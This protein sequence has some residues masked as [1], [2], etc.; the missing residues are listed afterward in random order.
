MRK[1][2]THNLHMQIANDTMSYIYNYIDTDIN[3]DDLA[4]KFDLSK[5]HLHKIFKEQMDANIYETIKSIRLQKASNLLISNKYSTVTQIANM[6]GYSSQ[7]SFIRAFKNRFNQTPKVWR[8]GAY[9]K[10][11]DEIL[12]SS[13]IELF[14]MDIFSSIKVKVIKTKKQNAYYIRH[15]GYNGEEVTKI[16]QKMQAWLYTNNIKEHT[17]IGIYHDNPIITAHENCFYVA[18]IVPQQELILEN[19]NLSNFEMPEALYATFELKGK[20]G[21]MLRLVQWAYHEWLPNSGYETTTNPSYSVFRKNQFLDEN[22][23]F[24]ATYYLPIKFA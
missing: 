22:Q 5:F 15:K 13:K 16:W 18:A 20:Y 23:E 11:S 6:C 19:T 2:S 1:K 4:I 12:A 10:Y 7:T 24:D 21:D 3:I 9:K 14:S 8:S 17:Q